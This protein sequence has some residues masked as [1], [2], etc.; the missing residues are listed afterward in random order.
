VSYVAAAWGSCGALL[1]LYVLRTLARERRLRR[2][3]E[4][5]REE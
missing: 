2:A 1:A 5:G 4:E 3:L